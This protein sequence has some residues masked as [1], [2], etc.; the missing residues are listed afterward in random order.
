MFDAATA[1]N[2]D[3]LRDEAAD[4]EHPAVRE[5]GSQGWQYQHSYHQIYSHTDPL[6]VFSFLSFP[7]L[8]EEVPPNVTDFIVLHIVNCTGFMVLPIL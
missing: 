2:D 4:Q 7:F 5:E 1:V 8:A 3:H 6:N